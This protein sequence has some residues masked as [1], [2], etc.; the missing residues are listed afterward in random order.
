[1]AWRALAL[2]QTEIEE[3]AARE[4]RKLTA[5]QF[6]PIIRDFYNAHGAEQMRASY[7]W[8]SPSTRM[9]PGE[10]AWAFSQPMLSSP[11][12]EP[13]VGWGSMHFNTR[14]AEQGDAVLI[15]GVFPDH[16][17]QGYRTKILDWMAARAKKLGA[18]SVSM[19]IYKTNEV[20]YKR[21]MR[22]THTD[23]SPWIY[24]GDCFYPPPGFGMFV[25]PLA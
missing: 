14:D 1:M 21:I 7:E 22:E 15:V 2:L 12:T 3:E 13:V 5:Q 20:H 9:Y 16:Q 25:R 23:G 10:R 19:I 24:A 8:D 17:R 4:A 6:A 11:P 18:T